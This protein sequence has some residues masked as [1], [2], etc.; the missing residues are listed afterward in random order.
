MGGDNFLE[1]DFSLAPLPEGLDWELTIDDTSVV[2]S[3]A[4]ELKGILGDFDFADGL[5]IKDIDA[6]VTEVQNGGTN[7]S[8]DVNNDDAVTADDIQAWLGL[9]SEA[10][11]KNF[12]SGDTDLNGAVEFADFLK[13]SG[14]FNAADGTWSHGNFD[15]ANG[16]D[17]ADFLA[18][19]GNFGTT[20]AAASVPEPNSGYVMA[21]S[22]LLGMSLRRRK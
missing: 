18:L 22:L 1:T 5:D 12:V 4:G 14:N 17:F 16:V 21:F 9:K 11:E 13:L 3:I 20:S 8:F 7:L 10:D 2:L 6:L 15:G 19:S